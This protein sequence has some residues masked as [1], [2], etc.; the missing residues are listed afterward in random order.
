M[1]ITGYFLLLLVLMACTE[2]KILHFS[3]PAG[4]LAKE[5]IEMTYGS[6]NTTRNGIIEYKYDQEGKLILKNYNGHVRYFNDHEWAYEE[7][8]YNDQGKL[9]IRVKYERNSNG[10]FEEA[11]SA[12]YEY[13]EAGRLDRIREVGTSTILYFFDDHERNTRIEYYVARPDFLGRYI[14]LEYN[15][16][17]Q[18][19]RES[20][21]SR[22]DDNDFMLVYQYESEYDQEGNLIRKLAV[23]GTSGNPE[24]FTSG[25]LEEYF[26]DNETGLVTEKKFYNPWLD[27]ALTEVTEF[28]YY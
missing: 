6:D 20:S 28:E 24:G 26:Y 18:L 13:D 12:D 15:Q 7:F 17:D 16:D 14:V 25:V 8:T 22:T 5:L 10:K 11:L 3:Q 2:D 1:K 19:I 4:K 23:D 9:S 27:Y 21:Y